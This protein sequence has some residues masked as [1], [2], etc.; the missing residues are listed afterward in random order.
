MTAPTR[1]ARPRIAYLRPPLVRDHHALFVE[2]VYTDGQPYADAADQ[3]DEQDQ[4]DGP[5]IITA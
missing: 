2:P 1:P 3:D 5:A 4:D